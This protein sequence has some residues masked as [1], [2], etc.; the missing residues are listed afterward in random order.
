MSD[1]LIREFPCPECGQILR[2]P[3]GSV[4]NRAECPHCYALIAVPARETFVENTRPPEAEI[5]DYSPLPNPLG[6]QDKPGA[7]CLLGLICLAMTTVVP[8]VMI[9]IGVGLLINGIAPAKQGTTI[10]ESFWLALV[11]GGLFI[12]WGLH[13]V[14]TGLRLWNLQPEAPRF[15]R[16][17]LFAGAG[18]LAALVALLILYADA[19]IGLKAVFGL[20]FMWLFYAIPLALFYSYLRYSK[21]IKAMEAGQLATRKS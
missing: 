9:A 12:T 10:N 4:G 21:R 17:Y 14:V 11:A 5:I 3:E 1:D 19:P 20:V 16:Y 13:T 18:Y 6:L 7:G 8:L 15:A 2:Y